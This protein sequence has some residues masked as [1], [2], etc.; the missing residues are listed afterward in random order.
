MDKVMLLCIWLAAG[1]LLIGG[2]I[3]LHLRRGVPLKLRI[4][5]L[6]IEVNIS[7]GKDN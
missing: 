1:L 5:G 7:S 4:K 6:G 3:V 2:I